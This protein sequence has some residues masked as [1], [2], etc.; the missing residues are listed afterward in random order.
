MPNQNLTEI[1]VIMD[2]SGSMSSIR[3]AMEKGFSKMIEE[4]KLIP[5]PCHVS[6]YQFDDKF[7]VVFE[8]NK[9]EDVNGIVLVPR[10]HTALLDA[11]GKAITLIGE[12]LA[13]KKDEERPGKVV[14]MIITDGAENASKE[15]TR[16]QIS[17]KIQH[18]QKH[19]NWQFAFLGANVDSF[20]E[21]QAIGFTSDAAVMDFSAN[22][23]GV[24]MVYDGMSS[25][26]SSYRKSR[27]TDAEL[28]VK[29]DDK[30]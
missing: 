16:K 19:Y 18:Q 1:A 26:L 24:N 13:K 29:K 11:C 17:E 6:L 25:G 3:E 8:E 22:E 4:Q 21:A 9:L 27:S 5:D 2:R 15:Y 20:A 14:V 12:R 7:D 28:R 30:K 23:R 10:G